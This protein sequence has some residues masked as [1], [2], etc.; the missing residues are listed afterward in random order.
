MGGLS[1]IKFIP[2]MEY[3][4][5]SNKAEGGFGYKESIGGHLQING[6]KDIIKLPMVFIVQH[7]RDP[8]L[9]K[10]YVSKVSYGVGY[11]TYI[12]YLAFAFVLISLFRLRNKNVLFFWM[13][14]VML[15]LIGTGSPFYY[16]LWKFFPG[17]SAQHNVGRFLAY[18]AFPSAFL[19]AF[20]ASF[21]FSKIETKFKNAKKI[22]LNLLLIG[23]LII[24]LV[25]L[26]VFLRIKDPERPY[27]NVDEE[28]RSNQLL[29]NLS[30][31]EDIFRITNFNTNRIGGLAGSHAIFNKLQ[32]VY[33][34]QNVWI[35]EYFNV[36]L[37]IAHN[38]PEK[39]YG[40][41]N[42]KYIYSNEPLNRTN[43]K[44]IKKFEE[45]EICIEDPNVDVG[46][47][48]PYLYENRLFLPR[49][50]VVPNSILVVGEEN[51][52]KQVMYGL[53]LDENF[54]PN[55]T[56]I[57]MGEKGLLNNYNTDFLRKF[58]V[59]FLT[60]DSVDQNSGYLLKNY[61]DS[62]GTIL[63]D[64][65]NGKN[66]ITNEDMN[67]MWDSFKGNYKEINISYYSPNKIILNLKKEEGFMVLSEKF[68]MFE[69]WKAKI[70]KNQKEIL[71]AN[72]I[73][74][75][76]YL[77]GDMGDLIFYYSSKSFR[78][79]AAI[80]SLTLITILIYFIVSHQKNKKL[81]RV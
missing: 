73:N 23:I 50:Y 63:P 14:I 16:L 17:F 80:S 78:T 36:Y 44:F 74:S 22:Y 52:A 10:G 30:K 6:I 68:F 19:A 77:N 56:V 57:I 55:N 79:G 53:M 71:R 72:G 46:I 59:I 5:V 65:I 15:F 18:L 3:A 47:D 58:S 1:A 54:H 76:V 34:F 27:T 20:G 45:C 35:P 32:I 64:I 61:V 66:S 31:R 21:L 48:G 75:A 51:V 8:H 26:G 13:I 81:K 12:G 43:I 2:L 49:A 25:D 29:Q 33:G 40:M 28:W 4:K 9:R 69:G 24:I 62:G 67:Q 37:A 60:Q 7:S 70:N 41:L 11:P 39:F 38:A 42:T